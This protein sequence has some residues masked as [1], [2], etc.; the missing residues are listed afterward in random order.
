M[1]VEIIVDGN[2]LEINDFV[3]KVAFEINNGFVTSLRE[4][5]EWTKLEIKLEK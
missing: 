2:S 4:V 5:P 1:N 3:K